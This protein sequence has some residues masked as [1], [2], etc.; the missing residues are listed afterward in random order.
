MKKRPLRR[1]IVLQYS[2]DLLA[3][4]A[5]KERDK[6]HLRGPTFHIEVYNFARI[7]IRVDDCIPIIVIKLDIA[8]FSV[9]NSFYCFIC[10]Y[11]CV[12]HTEWNTIKEIKYFTIFTLNKLLDE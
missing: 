9:M 8:V 1:H 11:R 12:V 4:S 6:K 3:I 2:V 10:V 5:D 7:T